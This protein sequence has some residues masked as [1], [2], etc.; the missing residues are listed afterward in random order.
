[1]STTKVTIEDLSLGT[2]KTS[3][4][5]ASRLGNPVAGTNLSSSKPSSGPQLSDLGQ[6]SFAPPSMIKKSGAP[7]KNAK[8]TSSVIISDLQSGA[9][10]SIKKTAS[11]FTDPLTGEKITPTKQSSV[12]TPKAPK[13][14]LT[15]DSGF[16]F[17]KTQELFTDEKDRLTD[18]MTLTLDKDNF[19]PNLIT[20]MDALVAPTPEYDQAVQDLEATNSPDFD[21]KKKT[22]LQDLARAITKA[23]LDLTH[24]LDILFD[25]FPQG[26]NWYRLLAAWD[27]L[28]DERYSHL[29]AKHNWLS[30]LDRLALDLI[31]TKRQH[32]LAAARDQG[33][34]LEDNVRALVA[35]LETKDVTLTKAQSG[36]LNQ[37]LT[38]VVRTYLDSVPPAPPV[39]GPSA[40]W[41]EEQYA[42]L[43]RRLDDLQ[44]QINASRTSADVSGLSDSL[45][46]TA[47]RLAR[48]EQATAAG[49]KK[50]GETSIS[51]FSKV[52]AGLENKLQQEKQTNA[53]RQQEL[54]DQL[55]RQHQDIKL[56]LTS[57]DE[58]ITAF[59][60]KQADKDQNQNKDI[61]QLREEFQS[62]SSDASRLLASTDTNL[63]KMRR[64]IEERLEQYSHQLTSIK[65]DQVRIDQVQTSALAKL[66]AQ[67]G[68]NKSQLASLT[69]RLDSMAATDDSFGALQARVDAQLQAMTTRLTNELDESHAKL[70][71]IA[72]QVSELQAYA[73]RLET[74]NEELRISNAGLKQEN[75]QARRLL[76][77][78]ADQLLQAVSAA[79]VAAQQAAL[80]YAQPTY[81]EQYVPTPAAAPEMSVPAGQYEAVSEPATPASA[82]MENLPAQSASVAD[83]PP[84]SVTPVTPEPPV[85]PEPTPAPVS[86]LAK[87]GF[88]H[89][90]L[91]PNSRLITGQPLD[92]PGLGRALQTALVGINSFSSWL[93][94]QKAAQASAP[95]AVATPAPEVAPAPAPATSDQS[96]F[97]PV[98]PLPETDGTDAVILPFM[99]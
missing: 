40:K 88:T 81:Q 46:A 99:S 25:S 45:T 75:W 76:G 20:I 49:I 14:S 70:E 67:V 27:V 10:S 61:R 18:L 89:S 77:G 68:S 31:G 44:N 37:K 24:R 60:Q 80:T 42:R 3:A 48:L 5:A 4:S 95:V 85:I 35:G 12:K 78:D 26:N 38:P 8:H 9:A 93:H 97:I 23:R 33:T 15:T 63:A 32:E 96:T 65:T 91:A 2:P 83:I 86:S 47:N 98:P 16:D 57:I 39:T 22:A 34:S 54:N 7:Q 55:T 79:P 17:S 11:S 28:D 1:M 66:T 51:S 41:V 36:L 58:A 72:T 29:L 19:V 13:N 73:S 21:A 50:L 56:K 6:V 52:A 94:E 90:R 69:D 87:L 71:K 43:S 84:M 59:R 82:P 92:F 30:I 53:T 62:I 74:E 64:D